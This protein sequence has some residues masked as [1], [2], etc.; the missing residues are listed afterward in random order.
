MRQGRNP[1]MCSLLV[2][3]MYIP[4]WTVEIE[5]VIEIERILKPSLK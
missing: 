5:I 4:R 1:D 3:L 2:N